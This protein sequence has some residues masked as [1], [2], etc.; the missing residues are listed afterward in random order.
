MTEITVNRS[1]FIQTLEVM[2]DNYILASPIVSIESDLQPGHF[3]LHAER[4]NDSPVRAFSPCEDEGVT[5]KESFNLINM[6]DEVTAKVPP[7]LKVLTLVLGGGVRIK[8][9]VKPETW[10]QV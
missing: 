2:R 1:V 8:P 4:V 3:I 9:E 6:I 10:A 7:T 5:F